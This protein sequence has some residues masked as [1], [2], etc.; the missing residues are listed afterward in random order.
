VGFVGIQ[1]PGRRP[2]D[3]VR[4]DRA[5]A[6]PAPAGDGADD[7]DGEDGTDRRNDDGA[8]V[9]RTVDRIAVEE[10]TGKEAA[11]ERADDAKHDVPDDPETLVTSDEEPGQIPCDR[12]KH[13]PR[14]DA[15]SITSIPID[16]R[17]D[18]DGAADSD[19]ISLALG[20]ASLGAALSAGAAD[21]GPVVVVVEPDDEQAT[22]AVVIARIKRIRFNIW[23]SWGW[24]TRDTCRRALTWNIT[25]VVGAAHRSCVLAR[26]VRCRR[27]AVGMGGSA[28][29]YRPFSAPC[30]A[31][32]MSM[33]LPMHSRAWPRPTRF[34][35]R[36]FTE[37]ADTQ[38][39]TWTPE[40]VD[41]D[42]DPVM[43][44]I[45]Y[46]TAIVAVLAAGLLSLV[47]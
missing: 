13:D 40:A 22:R 7:H 15:H 30:D 29:H 37:T 35:A 26:D 12:A 47:H 2:G 8:D 18:Q 44:A 5:S 21:S 23:T 34:R 1:L 3:S 33:R 31:S 36:M 14:N 27:L 16:T 10:G 4:S 45:Q 9:E 32:A 41:P 39:A 46:V 17:Q 19:G 42:E 24:T 20:A 11:D 25:T 43:L 6:D 38:L 28:H